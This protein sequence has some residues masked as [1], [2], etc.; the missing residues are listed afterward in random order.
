MSQTILSMIV[1]EFW[2]FS[3]LDRNLPIMLCLKLELPTTTFPRGRGATP[4]HRPSATVLHKPLLSTVLRKRS[5]LGP[6][7]HLISFPPNGGS[8]GGIQF[9]ISAIFL[10]CFRKSAARNCLFPLFF[11]VM[12]KVFLLHIKHN[13]NHFLSILHVTDQTQAVCSHHG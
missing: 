5:I 8:L 9:R 3:P 1:A 7:C 11:R 2:G 13:I 10:P 6:S 4:L 12:S